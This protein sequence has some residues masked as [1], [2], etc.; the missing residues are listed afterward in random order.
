[1][2]KEIIVAALEAKGWKLKS[3]EWEN[4]TY[5][6]RDG[7]EG[8]WEIY[9]DDESCSDEVY[10]K[11]CALENE[12]FKD[13]SFLGC[14]IIG[15]NSAAVLSVIKKMPTFAPISEPNPNECDATKAP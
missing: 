7:R 8:G 13:A 6:G 1:M 9:F 2:G 14:G 4:V 5:G 15:Y 10:E 11:L 12:I 3:I